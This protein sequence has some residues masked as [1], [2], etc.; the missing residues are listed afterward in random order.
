MTNMTAD[1]L[2]EIATLADNLPEEYRVA[3]FRELV[4]HELGGTAPSTSERQTTSSAPDEEGDGG[5]AAK[6]Q[7]AW[8]DGVVDQ[9]PDLNVVASGSR[10]LQAAWGIVELNKRGQP[11]TPAAIERLI[12]EELGVAP[13]D[14]ANLSSRL[15]NEFTPEYAT[16]KKVE[17][18][19]GYRYEATRAIAELFPKESD[20]S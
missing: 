12:R 7:A 3:A 9:M 8:F 5:K 18:G 2:K 14:K 15:G 19:Q 1:R 16:R 6:G 17:K 11:A 13:E 20:S 4:R 10:T